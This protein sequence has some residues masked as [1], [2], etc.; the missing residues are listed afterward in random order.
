MATRTPWRPAASILREQLADSTKLIICPGV[1]DGLT[2]RLAL[3]AGF[4]TLYMTGAGTA[5]TRLGAPDLALTTLTE[6]H[7]NAAMIASL[8][9]KV[10]VIADADTGFGGS[11][12]VARTVT[13]YIASNVA[14]LHLEDQAITKRCGHLQNKELVSLEIYLTRIRAAVMAREESGRDIVLIAR[15]DAL[16]SLGFEEAVRRLKAAAE[17]GADVAFLEGVMS[18]EQG[19]EV[20]KALAPT[21]CMLNVVA[22]G[23]TPNFGVKEAQEMGYRIAIWPMTALTAVYVGVNKA[24]KELKET[25]RIEDA[26]GGAGGIRDVFGVCGLTTCA[27]FD[28]KAGGVAFGNGV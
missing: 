18:E 3:A 4:D 24:L 16:Q 1:Y 9:N 15:T 23:V 6:M 26:E 8:D 19:R 14:A 7:A 13:S 11:L 25:G 2:A 27:E 10:P 21:P 17:A 20:C 5:A 28:K 22:G 12:S